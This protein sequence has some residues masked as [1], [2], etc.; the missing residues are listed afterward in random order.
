MP[1]NQFAETIFLCKRNCL[2]KTVGSLH[3]TP[4]ARGPREALQNQEGPGVA[5]EETLRTG[6]PASQVFITQLAANCWV[7][8]LKGQGA[9]PSN[10]TAETDIHMVN[11]GRISKLRNEDTLFNKKNELYVLPGIRGAGTKVAP[12]LSLTSYLPFD[13]VHDCKTE[14]VLSFSSAHGS[15][16]EIRPNKS[17]C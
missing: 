2:R 5:S 6:Q 8:L 16:L 13:R 1:L 3:S 7:L 15:L 9:A 12:Y 14:M 10:G 17:A 11:Y 4:W